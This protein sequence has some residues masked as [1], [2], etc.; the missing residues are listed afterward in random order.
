M[1]GAVLIAEPAA[2][3]VVLAPEPRARSDMGALS[4]R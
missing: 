4:W 2:V 3:T 1:E